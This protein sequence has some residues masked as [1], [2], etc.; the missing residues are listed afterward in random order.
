MWN[1]STSTPS[2]YGTKVAS[3]GVKAPRDPDQTVDP[4]QSAEEMELPEGKGL[5]QGAVAR[6]AE[7]LTPA[8]MTPYDPATGPDGRRKKP[9][10][11][12]EAARPLTGPATVASRSYVGV[13]ITTRGRNGTVS[14]RVTVPLVPPPPAPG[15]PTVSY[16]ETAV[17]VTWPPVAMTGMTQEPTTD[18][19]LESRPIGAPLPTLSYN[20]YQVAPS[21]TSAT[22]ART[23]LT[24]APVQDTTFEDPRVTW[25]ERRCYA[26][27]SVETADG[28]AI[29]SGA[30]D[31]ECAT[32]KDT[33]PPAAPKG[34]QALG[35]ESLISLIWEPSPEKDLAGYLVFRGKTPDAL[36]QI[37]PTPIQESRFSDGVQSG[38]RYFYA[39]K[40]VDKAG[41][42]G[43]PSAPADETAR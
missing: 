42:V 1:V 27:R 18:G 34:L 40:G 38:L 10:A 30:V 17:T 11:G 31:S 23:K 12:A 2:R 26:V 5:D 39:V 4:E 41:N 33:F 6:V 20:V 25:G 7:E 22:A 8:A 21:D 15:K 36:E 14:K 37:T 43:P 9:A 29:E 32:F 19:V 3:V 13:G 28:L 35:G 16:N 24:K